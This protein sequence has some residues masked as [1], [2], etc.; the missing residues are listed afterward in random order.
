MYH[1]AVVV[2]G[3]HLADDLAIELELCLG[4]V[5]VAYHAHT[6]SVA[7]VPRIT[8]ID[9]ELVAP[10]ATASAVGADVD[11]GLV[12]PVGL[13]ELAAALGIVGK[14]EQTGVEAA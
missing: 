9:G 3:A 11:H 6:L 1:A 14:V 4:S 12:A 7:V 5:G 10:T 8:G 13:A 2:V